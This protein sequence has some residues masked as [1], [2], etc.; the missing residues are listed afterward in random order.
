V[1]SDAL[2]FE[3]AAKIGRDAGISGRDEA[4]AGFE[5]LDSGAEVGEDG[6]DLAV[7]VGSSHNGNVAGQFRQG[8]DVVVGGA[9]LGAGDWQAGGD[10]ADGKNDA[11]RIPASGVA[12]AKGGA[13]IGEGN[14]G[15]GPRS[16]RSMVAEVPGQVFLVVGIAGDPGTVGQEGRQIGSRRIAFEPE[17]GPRGP[18]PLQAGGPGQRAYWCR[19]PIEAGAAR[20]VGFKQCAIG[21]QVS[22]LEGG[23]DACRPSAHHQQRHVSAPSKAITLLMPAGL[24]RIKSGACSGG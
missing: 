1:N 18:V 2:A 22:S 13:G 12:C 19:T 3:S 7:C 6:S 10:T 24:P 17:A 23:G 21:A 15:Q 5:Q 14:G 11:M 20:L 16:S 8:V 4:G 9:H